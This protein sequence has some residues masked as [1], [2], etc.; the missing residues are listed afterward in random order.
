RMV[1]YCVNTGKFMNPKTGKISLMIG[2]HWI[3]QRK[4]EHKS[5]RWGNKGR[6]A[7]VGSVPAKLFN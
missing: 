1:Y 6:D 5:L 2:C 7:I 3:Y 4:S